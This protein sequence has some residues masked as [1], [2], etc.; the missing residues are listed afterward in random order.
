ML[1]LFYQKFFKREKKIEWFLSLYSVL[2][3]W[4]WKL[5]REKSMFQVN[6]CVCACACM[7]IEKG[8]E[9]Y[10]PNFIVNYLRECEV[11]ILWLVA[12]N[13]NLELRSNFKSTT[14]LVCDL[15]ELHVSSFMYKIGREIIYASLELLW[16]TDIRKVPVTI[17]YRCRHH[18]II[19]SYSVFFIVPYA[20]FHP[21]LPTGIVK[22][23][24]YQEKK[25]EKQKQITRSLTLRGFT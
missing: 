4:P 15:G 1:C 23:S 20:F 8:M 2:E 7:F 14:D 25:T 6:V 24:D 5:I 22:R 17:N 16:G 13:I 11:S 18:Y 10:K 21:S 3:K 9:G 12:R 19:V